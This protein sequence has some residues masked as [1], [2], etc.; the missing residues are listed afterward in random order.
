MHQTKIQVTQESINFDLLLLLIMCCQVN[1]SASKFSPPITLNVVICDIFQ[2]LRVFSRKIC[3]LKSLPQN[4]G[5][6]DIFIPS[7]D[8]HVCEKKLFINV[9]YLWSEN[10]L[11]VVYPIIP[12]PIAANMP[13]L[14]L[15]DPGCFFQHRDPGGVQHTPPVKN[16]KMSYFGQFF[17]ADPILYI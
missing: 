16:F 6:R 2:G 17:Y 12:P 14:T 5:F 1:E 15:S 13:S 4:R 9:S 7:K 10:I 8:T 3:M 11:P